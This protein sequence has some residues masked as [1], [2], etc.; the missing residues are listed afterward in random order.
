MPESGSSGWTCLPGATSS[1]H[2][3]RSSS[4]VQ[5]GTT[6]TNVHGA[7]ISTVEHLM[8]ACYGLGLDNLI[9]EVDGPEVPIMDGSAA[10]YSEL[11]L[12]TGLK[13]QSAPRRCLRILESIEVTD[14]PKQA[15]LR[16]VNGDDLTLRAAIDYEDET[17]GR[18]EAQ[19]CLSP[20]SFAR[21]LSFARTFGFARDLD[22]L[23]AMGLGQGAS[24]EN[25]VAIDETGVMNPEGL[26]AHDEFVRHKMLDALGDLSLLGYRL[27]G[28]YE[29]EQPGHSINNLL[30][31][32]VLARP[33]A[34]S[35]EFAGQTQEMARQPLRQAASAR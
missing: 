35:L 24:M 9:V 13:T 20:E 14:G 15:A 12:Q 23:N 19:L 6:L 21:D 3:V 32:A 34:W 5:L 17:I 25:A 4:E 28:A 22:A 26:R 2:A 8:A 18:Q 7:S 30:V 16:P 31:R 11:I 10:L 27:I 33:E 29:S 1:R